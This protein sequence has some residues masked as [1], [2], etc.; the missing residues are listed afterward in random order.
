MSAAENSVNPMAVPA[1]GD[2]YDHA[3]GEYE[4]DWVCGCDEDG[5]TCI[6]LLGGAMTWTGNVSDLFT[7]GFTKRAQGEA[8]RQ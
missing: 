5:D 1:I 8:C 4:V 3:T 6:G 7:E 2:R